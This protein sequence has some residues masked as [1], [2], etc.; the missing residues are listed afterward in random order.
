MWA[1]SVRVR[2]RQG[3]RWAGTG[4]E[5]GVCKG[6]GSEHGGVGLDECWAALT[7]LIAHNSSHT[8]HRKQLIAHRSSLLANP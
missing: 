4:M 2:V 6:L 8:A 1:G 3:L 7:H 5:R